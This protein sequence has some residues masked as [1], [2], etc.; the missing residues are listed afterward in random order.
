[1]TANK[2]KPASKRPLSLT[3]VRGVTTL[4]CRVSPALATRWAERLFFI[5]NSAKRPA[6]EVPYYDSP[7]KSNYDFSGRRVALYR[8]GSGEQTVILVHGWG[9]RGTRLGHLAEPLSLRG[10]RVVSVDLPGH[11]D[12][13]GN[14]TNLPEIAELLSRLH[15]DFSPVHAMIGH[16]FGGM[17]TVAALHKYRLAVERVALIAAPYSMAYIF[18]QFAENISLTPEVR[19]RLVTRIIN[20]FERTRQVHVYEFSPDRLVASLKMPFLIVHDREDREVGFE[21]GEGYAQGLPNTE[22]I[23]TEG[24]GHRR[25]LRDDKV[26]QALIDFIAQSPSR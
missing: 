3:I 20:R 13:D 1:M 17:A 23:G 15:A 26:V 4:L 7:D 16:S 18:D 6:S 25:I 22:F 10:Y 8:W 5:T 11:G 12:S 21:Q 14:S 9:S 2:A 24:L 19:E